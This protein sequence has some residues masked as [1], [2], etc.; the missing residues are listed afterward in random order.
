MVFDLLC[1]RVEQDSEVWVHP[2]WNCPAGTGVF[3][4][5][6]PQGGRAGWGILKIR[7]LLNELA[8]LSFTLRETAT[9]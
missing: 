5:G 1:S 8:G 9:L 6:H 3:G 4:V 7:K 2:F